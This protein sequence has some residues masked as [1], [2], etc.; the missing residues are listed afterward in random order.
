MSSQE[1]SAEKNNAFNAG[2]KRKVERG[3]FF[4]PAGVSFWTSGYVLGCKRDNLTLNMW[5]VETFGHLAGQEGTAP[6]SLPEK[7]LHDQMDIQ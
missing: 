1:S 5:Q 4:C 3:G 7:V 6:F 2:R